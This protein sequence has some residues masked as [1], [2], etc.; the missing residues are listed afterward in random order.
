LLSYSNDGIQWGRE[1]YDYYL[2]AS[3]EFDFA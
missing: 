3:K 1:L 2:G